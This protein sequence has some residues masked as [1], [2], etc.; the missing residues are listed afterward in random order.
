MSELIKELLRYAFDRQNDGVVV[1]HKADGCRQPHDDSWG[2]CLL[3]VLNQ[4]GVA[5][6][7]CR[8]RPIAVTFGKHVDEDMMVVGVAD[9][10][11][12]GSR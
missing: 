12:P 4:K 8:P 6:I 7:L 5:G 2:K 1:L 3:P 9:K 10:R 11:S